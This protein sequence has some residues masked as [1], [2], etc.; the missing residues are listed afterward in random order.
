L[1]DIGLDCTDLVLYV[2]S[3]CN[4]RCRHCYVGNAL[5]A[6]ANYLE[7]SSV[8]QLL[9][10]LRALERITVLGGEPLLHSGIVPIL[11]A[12]AAMPIGEKRL[13][14]NLTTL[15]RAMIDL[16]TLS[17]VR[18][19][20]S[21]D[22]HSEE[23]HDRI[24]GAGTFKQTMTNLDALVGAGVDVE[25]THTVNASNLSHVMAL[26]DLLKEHGVSRLNLHKMSLKG[27]A[28]AHREWEVSP[29]E[30]R[31]LLSDLHRLTPDQSVPLA[32]RYELGY[33]TPLEMDYLR[34]NGYRNHA[35]RSFY[36]RAGQRVVLYADGRVYISSEA[37]GTEAFVGT[38]AGDE[39]RINPS[40]HNE[41]R[42]SAD[43]SFDPS[44][45]DARRSGDA[46]Y[47]I[48]ISVSFRLEIVL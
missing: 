20:A 43:P 30:W 29:T 10:T 8:L 17:D 31:V 6:Q 42:V 11:S 40:P 38:F 39:F 32:V 1:A 35:Q 48:P 16:L 12:V 36:A 13:T 33:V 3:E 37:F 2:N 28:L 45:L 41:L 46:E 23:V 4:L 22:G 34:E 15:S 27:N 47:V 24:R 9:G 26:I 19:C 5:L 14:T 18:V 25:V 7:T 21:L 44:W